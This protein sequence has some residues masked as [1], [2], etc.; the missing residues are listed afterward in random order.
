MAV[1]TT[2]TTGSN[3]SANR[4]AAIK[5]TEGGCI[6]E[7]LKSALESQM[8]IEFPDALT[9]SGNIDVLTST[10]VNQIVSQLVVST[11]FLLAL[12][13]QLQTTAVL[14]TIITALVASTDFNT[15][16]DGKIDTKLADAATI[17]AIGTALLA[18]TTFTDAMVALILADSSVTAAINTAVDVRIAELD[19]FNCSTATHT[20]QAGNV[21]NID[22]SPVQPDNDY[23]FDYQPRFF[24]P[25][26]GGTN[27]NDSFI[28]ERTPIRVTITFPNAL[29]GD[30]VNIYQVLIN[31]RA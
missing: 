28:L 29:P 27:F 11:D 18:S 20:V 9:D 8:V 6:T 17:T 22:L 26:G 25:S 21:V 15:A 24:T 31:C 1:E 30:T 12:S 23:W 3:T 7:A 5:I 19:L 13:A 16:V 10:A 4:Q 14:N 2:S